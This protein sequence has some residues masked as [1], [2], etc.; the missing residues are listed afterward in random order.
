MAIHVDNIF[1]DLSDAP[2][3]EHLRTLF[4]NEIICI[5]RIVSQ[6]H[7]S[8]SG[9]WYDQSETEWVMV[10]RGRATLQFEGGELIEMKEGDQLIIP[11]HARHRVNQTGPDTVWLAVHI[12]PRE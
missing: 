9:F 5:E 12:K 11:S 2:G 6:S 7:S 3:Q 1:A 10:L 8:P 4:A